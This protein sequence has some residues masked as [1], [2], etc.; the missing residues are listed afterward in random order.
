M[1]TASVHSMFEVAPAN[2]LSLANQWL[3]ERV[4][5]VAAD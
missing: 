4:Y 1:H 2:L 5:G 3:S